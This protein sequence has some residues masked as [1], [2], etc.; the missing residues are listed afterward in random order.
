MDR[1]PTLPVLLFMESNNVENLKRAMEIGI[2]E[3]LFPPLKI[4]PNITSFLDAATGRIDSTIA[5][6]ESLVAL[7]KEKRQALISHAVTRGLSELVLLRPEQVPADQGDQEPVGVVLVHIPILHHRR[8][9]ARIKGRR[10]EEE[11]PELQGPSCRPG[12]LHVSS[13]VSRTRTPDGLEWLSTVAWPAWTPTA[14]WWR[15][16][17]SQSAVPSGSPRAS[18]GPDRGSS[19]EERVL[20]P[21]LP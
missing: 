15:L 17:R 21:S 2:R 9:H 13:R 8:Y 11:Q 6:Y 16:A 12:F 5:E 20:S 10:C 14:G 1:F 7:L 19:G 18:P 3:C 4:Q